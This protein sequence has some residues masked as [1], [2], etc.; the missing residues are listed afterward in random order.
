MRRKLYFIVIT[1][2]LL[3][4][5]S[6]YAAT[7]NNKPYSRVVQ[8]LK[9]IVD[10]NPSVKK[11]LITAFR[12]MP[13]ESYWYGKAI[14]SYWKGKSINSIYPFFNNWLYY[15]PEPN[16]P[17]KYAIPFSQLA[18]S[19]Q[20]M[21]F[22][23]LR[24]IR[25]WLITFFRA[26]GH[27]I[28]SPASTKHLASWLN[29]PRIKIKQYII[30]KHGY[31][32]FNEFFTRKLK[33]GEREIS[34]MNNNEIIDSPNDG[35]M[36]IMIPALK[37]NSILKAKGDQLN[38]REIFNGNPIADKFIGGP[39]ILTGLGI[40][41]YHHY[42]APVSG[43]VVAAN[44]F[45]GLYDPDNSPDMYQITYKHRRGIYIFQN[46]CVGYVGMVP[47]GFWMVGSVNLNKKIG[48]YVT[49]GEDVGHFAYG[50]SAI[51]LFFEPNK[52]S[53]IKE[54]SKKRQISVLMGQY[55][56]KSIAKCS[57]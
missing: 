48:D 37:N 38:I 24:P 1:I 16:T 57:N 9:Q 25:S 8:N 54:L 26:R 51:L 21:Q 49:K 17:F 52:I 47:I 27:Y 7:Q 19:K 28:D 35:T 53:L 34:G 12:E 14:K 2:T 6:V 22:V 10:S 4:L 45:S 30:P 41:N 18:Y 23:R 31:K 42:H 36:Q 32:S 20:G 33:K 40:Y 39:V 55:F 29:D 50:G 5:I 44:T 43:K 46:P 11:Q 3:N 15:N 56:A 13:S